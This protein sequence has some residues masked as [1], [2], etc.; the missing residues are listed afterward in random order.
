M[1]K[2]NKEFMTLIE[3]IN[4]SNGKK[5]ILGDIKLRIIDNLLYDSNFHQFSF[6]KISDVLSNDWEIGE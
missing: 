5:I 2:G 6:T 3:A 4:E 1:I